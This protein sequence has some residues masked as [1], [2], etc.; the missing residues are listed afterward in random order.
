MAANTYGVT[1]STVQQFFPSAIP[2]AASARV[3]D[4]LVT[5]WIAN[6]SEDLRADL[7]PALTNDEDITST[8]AP[9]A[10]GYMSRLLALGV[11]VKIL[12]LSGGADTILTE[13]LIAEYADKRK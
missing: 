6:I 5:S 9:V 4:G 11:A 7:Y 3:D 8:A 2:F 1:Y 13:Q 10:Y 12:Q